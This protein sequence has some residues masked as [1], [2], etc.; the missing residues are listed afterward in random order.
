MCQKSM[1][2][3]DT[4][5]GAS[6]SALCMIDIACSFPKPGFIAAFTC[7]RCAERGFIIAHRA[8][9]RHHA[10]DAVVVTCAA[11]TFLAIFCETGLC[12]AFRPRIGLCDRQCVGTT[13]RR[14]GAGSSRPSKPALHSTLLIL[15]MVQC[16][17]CL[18]L[19]AGRAA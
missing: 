15:R 8:R 17:C 11:T 13:L 7:S 14:P 9:A 12:C 16:A 19:L 18:L 5:H 2:E 3:Q 4:Q 6:A 10:P 1:A